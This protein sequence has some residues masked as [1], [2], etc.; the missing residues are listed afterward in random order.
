ML[1]IDALGGNA[2]YLAGFGG[3][4]TKGP[5]EKLIT[6]GFLCGPEHTFGLVSDF[7]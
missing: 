3:A 4:L 2:I 5:C 6:K 1:S 7:H